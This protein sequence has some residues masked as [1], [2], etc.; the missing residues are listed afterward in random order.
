MAR[1]LNIGGSVEKGREPGDRTTGSITGIEALSVGDSVEKENCGG[2]GAAASAATWVARFPYLK[3]IDGTRPLSVRDVC[4]KE[5]LIIISG[6]KKVQSQGEGRLGFGLNVFR[7]NAVLYLSY[8]YGSVGV[9]A[10]VRD[11]VE[12]RKKILLW[13]S[14]CP[15]LSVSVSLSLTRC[16]SM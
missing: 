13:L 6:E 2:E 4:R 16:L 10:G 8:G 9:E 12:V 11:R 1:R 15:H 3:V 14:L 5:A 7:D